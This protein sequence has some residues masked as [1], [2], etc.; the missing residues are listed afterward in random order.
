MAIVFGSPEAREVLLKDFQ[1]R[2]GHIKI[3]P[4]SNGR[5]GAIMLPAQYVAGDWRDAFP[6]LEDD[7]EGEDSYA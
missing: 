6:A 7:E 5:G 3:M 2:N 4:Q 1:R